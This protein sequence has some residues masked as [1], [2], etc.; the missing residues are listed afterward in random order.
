MCGAP[1]LPSDLESSENGGL[2]TSLTSLPKKASKGPV[3][4]VEYTCVDVVVLQTVA[5]WTDVFA[6][7]QALEG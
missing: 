1:L 5:S 2:Y 6:A 7:S 3:R 4:A